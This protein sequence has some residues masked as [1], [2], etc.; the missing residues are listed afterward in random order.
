MRVDKEIEIFLRKLVRGKCC[1]SGD[2]QSIAEKMIEQHGCCW[3]ELLGVDSLAQQTVDEQSALAE[4]VSNATDA[5]VHAAAFQYAV[6]NDRPTSGPDFK[7][8]WASPREAVAVLFGI[9]R[10]EDYDGDREALA[11]CVAL[12]TACVGGRS[13]DARSGETLILSD[14]GI[15][16]LPEKFWD[17]FLNRGE[18]PDK[19]GTAFL[20]GHYGLG[21]QAM[22]KFCDWQLILSKRIAED[23]GEEWGVLILWCER[24]TLPDG[25][26]VLHFLQR[27]F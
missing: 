21:S 16:Q 11:S 8:M 6:Q 2:I 17:T 20:C 23:G 10:L 12:V 25:K 22:T 24:K 26:D 4:L 27:I 18:S 9:E 15:G 7:T 13:D 19:K 3:I 14:F 5:V 1:G